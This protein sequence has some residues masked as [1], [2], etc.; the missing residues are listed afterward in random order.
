M[1]TGGFFG[2]CLYLFYPNF[3]AIVNAVKNPALRDFLFMRC[4]G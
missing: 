2:I 4:G 1:E 3:W